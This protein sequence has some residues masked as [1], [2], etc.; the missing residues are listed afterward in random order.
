M[1]RDIADYTAQ[2]QRLPFEPI[3][4]AFRRRRVLGEIARRAP[5]R[6]LEVGCGHAPLFTD[7]RGMDVTVVEPSPLF[8]AHARELAAARA[9]VTVVEGYIEQCAARLP[10]FDMV[11]V[12]CLLH[13]VPDPQALL[14]AVKAVCG[15]ATDL[16]VNVPNAQSLHRLLAVAM[17]LIP[18]PDALSST[19]QR[20]QQRF[21]Y[22]A[23]SL[24][25]ELARAGFAVCD[26]GP[27]FVKPFT[28]AQM[29]RLVDDGF[30]TPQMLDGLDRLA[31]S[32]PGL[33][34][35]I[36]VNARLADD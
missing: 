6:L 1:T 30:M 19:Q 20:M 23:D 17:G 33:G 11:V 36:W 16:H 7:L 24:D 35:E 21:T 2:Y 27:I 34:S 9:D 14:G 32:L 25:A 8:A 15:R 28:H 29:Q 31:Q 18:A 13:E 5:A 26:R 12:S 3:Q 4:A 10:V 22:D